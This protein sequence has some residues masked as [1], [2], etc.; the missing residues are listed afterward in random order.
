MH[1][2][3]KLTR[4]LLAASALCASFTCGAFAAP[5]TYTFTATGPITGTLGSVSIGGTGQLLTFTFI[6]DTT[7]VLSFSSPVPGHEILIG[8][9]SVSV[10]D[11]STGATIASGN[12]ATTDGIFVSIDNQNGGV[13]FGSAGA[14]PGSAGFPG[15]PAYPLGVPI[16]PSDPHISYDLTSDVTI[17]SNGTLSCLGFPFTCNTPTALAT[18]GGDL[19]LGAAGDV[20]SLVDDGTFTAVVTP[21]TTP[22]PA[23]LALLALGVAGLGLT[24]RKSVA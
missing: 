19:I 17:S 21:V 8:A 24:R 4:N 7:N 2:R 20:F 1:T 22:E 9:G 10:T 6:G 13:G 11:I 15:N 3:W 16:S 18:S 14:P 12:F 23:S 5:V